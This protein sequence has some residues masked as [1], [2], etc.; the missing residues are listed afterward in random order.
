MEDLGHALV[1]AGTISITQLRAHYCDGRPAR[2]RRKYLKS[3]SMR[4]FIFRVLRRLDEPAW[5]V[6]EQENYRE[7]SRAKLIFC[8]SRPDTCFIRSPQRALPG[9][10]V[11][12]PAH[13]R[14]LQ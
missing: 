12:W 7:P 9:M 1:L 13:F 2:E 10:L 3:R 11:E 14:K 5:H 4:L 6:T 8:D